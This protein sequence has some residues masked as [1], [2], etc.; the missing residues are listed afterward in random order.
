MRRQWTR[1]ADRMLIHRSKPDVVVAEHGLHRDLLLDLLEVN[2]R[3][4]HFTF[5]LPSTL[6]GYPLPCQEVTEYYVIRSRSRPLTDFSFKRSCVISAGRVV[7]PVFRV[8]SAV[9]SVSYLL[10]YPCRISC[11]TRVV[12]PVQM[13]KVRC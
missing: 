8:I 12:S 1:A 11:P 5:P 13:M 2:E 6:Y 10:S 7:S 9:Q 3:L 4:G